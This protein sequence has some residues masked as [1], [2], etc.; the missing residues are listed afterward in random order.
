MSFG[1]LGKKLEHSY[2]PY[3]HAMIGAYDYELFDI[4]ESELEDFMEN[5]DF[6]GLNV[7]MPY[8]ESIMKYVKCDKIAERIG[9]VN[10]IYY[11]DGELMGT[12]TDF[13]G[14]MYLLSLHQITLEG[15]KV[16]IL[17]SGGASKVA[18]AV[19]KMSEASKV[20]VASRTK[21]EKGYV[22]YRT[23]P[24]DADIIINATPLG[25]YPA[26]DQQAVDLSDFTGPEAVIDLIYNPYRTRLLQQAEDLGIKAVNGLAMLVAQAT[27][28]AGHF[29]GMNYISYNRQLL[30][31]IKAYTLNIVL[32]GMP[33]CGK[34]FIGEKLAEAT[35]RKFVDIDRE[36]EAMEGKTIPEIFREDG[37]KYFRNLETELLKKYCKESQLVI[38]TGGGTVL[39]KE[40]RDVIRSNSGVVFLE[41][42]LNRLEKKGRPLS[43]DSRTLEKMYDER[44][45]LYNGIKDI[46]VNN[47]NN[48]E[49]I[50]D[51]ILDNL[52]GY[53][54]KDYRNN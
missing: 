32:V 38:A 3:L 48:F 14:F 27:K 6:N 24:L 4:D 7:T 10:T 17:G 39:R 22:S 42:P 30:T 11:K 13:F 49:I 5:G 40:N 50:I 43:T 35:Q 2:S 45:P 53:Y 29:T 28:A 12:N 8:K 47:D 18:Q 1:L 37:E 54:E 52:G 41:R 31:N 23:L 19:A 33:G 9:A 44:L 26:N 21:T 16:L 20:F 51:K 34:S 15:K 36:I 25:M 46:S